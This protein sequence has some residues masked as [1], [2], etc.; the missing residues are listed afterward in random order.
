MVRSEAEKN[1]KGSKWDICNKQ[2]EGLALLVTHFSSE[3]NYIA[4]DRQA[5]LKEMWDTP[6]FVAA[7]AADIIEALLNENFPKTKAYKTIKGF[8]VLY[9]GQH[10]YITDTNFSIIQ[11]NLPMHEK[12]W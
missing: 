6:I 4:L 12:S 2:T 1:L 8:M 7:L 3:P 9:H 10:F 5:D 11:V